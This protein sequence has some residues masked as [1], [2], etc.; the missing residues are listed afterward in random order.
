MF[1][2]DNDQVL[3]KV[4]VAVDLMED[5]PWVSLPPSRQKRSLRLRNVLSGSRGMSALGEL[6]NSS[7]L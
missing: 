3:Q 7:R 6:M 2:C 4:S 5:D 1:H